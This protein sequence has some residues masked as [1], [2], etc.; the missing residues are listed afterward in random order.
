MKNVNYRFISHWL[1]KTDPAKASQTLDDVE[2]WP[3]WWPGLEKLERLEGVPGHVGS[4]VRCTWRA[5]GYRLNIII[6]IIDYQPQQIL[7]FT[8]SGDLIGEGSWTMQK[9]GEDQTAMQIV[10][11]VAT[12]KRWMNRLAPILRPFFERNHQRVMKKGERGF[13][14]FLRENYA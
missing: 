3:N 9:A 2:S 1:I 8:S 14:Q 10:W 12:T 4:R 13:N 7:R 5:S 11:N 6:E